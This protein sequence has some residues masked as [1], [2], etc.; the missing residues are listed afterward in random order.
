MPARLPLSRKQFLADKNRTFLLEQPRLRLLR[1]RL[2]AIGGQEVVLRRDAHLEELLARAQ[3]WKRV[4][5]R[6]I[7]GEVNQ[8]HRNAA[9]TYLKA[10]AKH[11][12]VTGWVLHGDD[13]VWRQHSWVL[14]RDELCETTEPAKIY[15]GVILDAAESARFVRAELGEAA[16][17][18]LPPL[19]DLDSGARARG[20][21][22]ASASAARRR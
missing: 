9:S 1:R 20:T 16:A 14:R 13:V 21:R 6:K 17:A 7:R 11:R 10:P 4:A 3:V 19:H 18:A 5:P 15:V 2:L 12:I 8:C 22:A